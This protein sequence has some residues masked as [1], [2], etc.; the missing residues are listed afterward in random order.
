MY[1]LLRRTYSGYVSHSSVAAALFLEHGCEKI[2]NDVM[3][4]EL[5]ARHVDPGAF[6]WASVQL[7][8]GIAKT[9]EAIEAWFAGRLSMRPAVERTPAGFGSL[10][11]GILSDG[12]VEPS[13][14]ACF[15]AFVQ[16][17]V[18]SGGSVLMVENDPL[19]QEPEFLAVTLGDSEVRSTLA[20]GEAVRL[21]GFHVV[22]TE[23][24]HWVENVAGLG[25]CGAQ[26]ILGLVSETARPGH[27][28]VPV[29]Q[30]ATPGSSLVA[31]EDVDLVLSGAAEQDLGAIL[32]LVL[33]I[34]GGARRAAADKQGNVDFQITRGLLG[35]ST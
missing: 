26:V 32:H 3:R 1:A 20:Y 19:L 12:P 8:G 30:V 21:P 23:S 10:L 16:M 15:G 29:L 6:G 34:S 31:S 4:H 24:R 35:V 22:R 11:F 33:E 2:V 27:P 9:L 7:D 18:S 14:A 5:A 25:G 13:A 17:A 28:F